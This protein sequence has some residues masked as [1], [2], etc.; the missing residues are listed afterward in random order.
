MYLA[1]EIKKLLELEEIISGKSLPSLI[2][3]KIKFGS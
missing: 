2:R 1:G 3:Y